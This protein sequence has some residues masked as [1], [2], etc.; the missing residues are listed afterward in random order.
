MIFMTVLVLFY[1]ATWLIPPRERWSAK[2]RW[3]IALGLAMTVAGVTHLLAP[4]PFVQHIPT[5]IPER[6]AIVYLTGVIEIAL[7]AA[8]VVPRG[9]NLR[10]AGLALA[11]F[12]VAVFPGNVYV[13]VAGVEVD[14][15]PGGVY[16]WL[17]LPLQLLFVWL[18]LWTTRTSA[19]R[20]A[21]SATTAELRQ[22]RDMSVPGLAHDDAA[23]PHSNR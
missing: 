13:A 18:A 14:G 20:P 11:A 12:L 6:F 8:I 7:G 19:S 3:R 21:P 1:A 10:L 2:N 15:Q 4:T 23:V 22:A 17:R 9:R 16:P 5:W